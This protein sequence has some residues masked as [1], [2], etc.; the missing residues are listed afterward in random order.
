M[1]SNP[2]VRAAVESNS[3][4]V[5]ESELTQ[6]HS[7][8]IWRPLVT[9]EMPADGIPVFEVSDD[10]SQ[11]LWMVGAHGGAGTSTLARLCDAGD[12]G[13]AWPVGTVFTN[14]VVVA[15]G[16]MRGLRAAQRAALQWTSGAVP[17]V[18]LIGVA[19]VADCAGRE[20]KPLKEFRRFVSGAFPQAWF[21]PWI[22]AWR[23]SGSGELS[24]VPRMVRKIVFEISQHS[25]RTR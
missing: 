9:R 17:S 25:E 15:R 20:P 13:V 5:E 23:T 7:E 3:V 24:T 19:F 16:D 14:A 18:N 8:K 10:T 1:S 11:N 21:I 22:D 12:A 4:P 2:W 6:P